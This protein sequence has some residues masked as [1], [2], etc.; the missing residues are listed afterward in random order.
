MRSP[1]E[2]EHNNKSLGLLILYVGSCIVQKVTLTNGNIVIF[3]TDY[4][5]FTS[6]AYT[7]KPKIDGVG[8]SLGI[9]RSSYVL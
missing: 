7:S 3:K 1:T 6:N 4:E 9:D 2:K 5:L 8:F